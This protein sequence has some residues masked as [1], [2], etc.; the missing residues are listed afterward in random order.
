MTYSNC[1]GR[2]LIWISDIETTKLWP[3]AIAN[4]ER[5]MEVNRWIS[6]NRLELVFRNLPAHKFSDD[7]RTFTDRPNANQ[8]WLSLGLQNLFKNA[9]TNAPQRRLINFISCSRIHNFSSDFRWV[10][11][12]LSLI[13]KLWNTPLTEFELSTLDVA[14]RYDVCMFIFHKRHFQ[15]NSK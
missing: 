6:D 9:E 3:L 14:E 11:F 10:F 4:E 5:W 12:F 8:R 7:F 1:N 2:Y 13:T 15:Q